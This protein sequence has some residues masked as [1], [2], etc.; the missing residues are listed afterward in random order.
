MVR[1]S[2]VP[3]CC[4]PHGTV[5]ATAANGARAGHTSIYNGRRGSADA[6]PLI[7]PHGPGIPTHRQR[8]YPTLMS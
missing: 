3:Q 2:L 4:A 1:M 7:F 6:G 5:F 8:Y